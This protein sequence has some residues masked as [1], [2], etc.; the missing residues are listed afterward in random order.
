MNAAT[1]ARLNRLAELDVSRYMQRAYEVQERQGAVSVAA[2]LTDDDRAALE[3][4]LSITIFARSLATMTGA[5]SGPDA[6]TLD[7]TIAGLAGFIAAV[8][9]EGEG[10]E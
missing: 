1:R 4:A 9:E 10:T 3:R 8:T 5:I 7:A 6:A 2:C